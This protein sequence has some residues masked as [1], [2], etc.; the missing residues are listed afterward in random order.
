MSISVVLQQMGVI[1]ILVTVGIYL[2]K[3]K[4]VD[5]TVSQ[6]IS[7]IVMDICNPAL[8]LASILTGNIDAGHGEL[9]SAILFGIGFYAG[10][11][12]LGAVIPI[13]LRVKKDKRR[14]YNLMVVYTNVGFIGIPVARAILP[15]N[16]ILYVIVCNV[17]YCLLFYTHGITVLSNGREKMN[18]KKVFSP[19][20]IMSVFSLVVCW[21]KLTLPPIIS[22]SIS[23]IGNT[24]VFLSMM[25][26]GVSIARS[27]ILKGLKQIPVWGYIVVR[28]IALP[29]AM[30]FIMKAAGCDD[31]MTLGFSLMAMMPVGN[32]P[33]I[34]SEKIGEE[35]ETLSNAITVTTIVSVFTITGL[36]VWFT[37]VM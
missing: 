23:Y 22:S 35:T 7:V 25:L 33:L 37:S 26:L 13:I 18:I 29:I 2:Y 11:M 9:L 16:A 15:D 24:T 27:D 8:V 30:F 34:Q 36:M 28:M 17:M 12:V 14:F 4:I 31:I 20:T 6:R 5:D 1:V 19:G 3:R 21:F 32:L 10:L